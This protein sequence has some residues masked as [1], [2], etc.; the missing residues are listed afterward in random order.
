MENKRENGQR[1]GVNKHYFVENRTEN[2]GVFPMSGNVENPAGMQVIE[3]RP[4]TIYRQNRKGKIKSRRV[5]QVSFDGIPLMNLSHSSD[6]APEAIVFEPV[7]T[8]VPESLPTPKPSVEPDT[9]VSS[10]WFP[11]PLDDKFIKAFEGTGIGDIHGLRRAFRSGVIVDILE[12]KGLS[13]D[14][15]AELRVAVT[16]YEVKRRRS[17]A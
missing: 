2:N 8:V 4:H 1:N 15:I 11:F 6:P 17:R 13:K 16:D 14:D 7:T 5:I 12:Y 10:S 9:V 3:V